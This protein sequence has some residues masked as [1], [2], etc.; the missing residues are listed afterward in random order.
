MTQIFFSKTRNAGINS[1]N[2]CHISITVCFIKNSISIN[3]AIHSNKSM[4]QY[5]IANVYFTKNTNALHKRK[6]CL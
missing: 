6:S 2:V 3:S 4:S 5:P 1:S